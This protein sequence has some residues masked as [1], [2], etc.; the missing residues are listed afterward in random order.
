MAN[1]ISEKND[2]APTFCYP[3]LQGHLVLGK[4]ELTLNKRKRALWDIELKRFEFNRIFRD[5]KFIDYLAL[6]EKL[7][8]VLPF[9]VLKLYLKPNIKYC[10][11][12]LLWVSLIDSP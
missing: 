9:I 11:S 8:E 10:V 6:I 3:I 2:D 5:F 4:M 1:S 7:P 12:T